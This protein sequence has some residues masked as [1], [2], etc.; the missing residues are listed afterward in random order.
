MDDGQ[1][2]SG[3]DPLGLLG[4]KVAAGFAL[5]VEPSFPELS[6]PYPS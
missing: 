2:G 6:I 5:T 1:L 4:K 3:A